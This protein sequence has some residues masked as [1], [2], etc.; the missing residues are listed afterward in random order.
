MTFK[1]LYIN[2][3]N[4]AR[5]NLEAIFKHSRSNWI[6]NEIFENKSVCN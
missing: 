2:L 4:L 6:P 5:L 3:Y 1:K